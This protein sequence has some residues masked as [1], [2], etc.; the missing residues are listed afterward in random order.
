[1]KTYFVYILANRKEGTIYIGITSDI[2]RRVYEHKAKAG[3]GFTAEYN[4][5]RLVYFE[6]HSDVLEA[7]AREKKLKR[8]RREWKI[9]LIQR[10]NPDWRDLYDDLSK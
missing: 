3:D 1:M 7:I 10:G 5:D 9:E 4:V 2:I 6:Q 8:W